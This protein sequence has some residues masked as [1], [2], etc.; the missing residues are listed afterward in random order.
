[1]LKL[2]DVLE[3]NI[4]IKRIAIVKSTANKCSCNSFGNNKT[5]T[6][7]HDEGHECDKSSND[8]FAFN[9]FWRQFLS[10]LIE[11]QQFISLLKIQNNEDPFRSAPC[12]LFVC[13]SVCLL[14]MC[15][16]P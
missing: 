12:G 4:K 11:R 8:K 5:Y 15:L 10:W 14:D 13:L 16:L 6:C 7:K 3:S 1:M 2:Q 9:T